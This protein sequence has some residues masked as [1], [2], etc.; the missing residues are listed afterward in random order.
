MPVVPCKYNAEW[1]RVGLISRI[2]APH[3]HPLFRIYC[4]IAL[5]IIITMNHCY[6]S[7]SSYLYTC[8]L[9]IFGIIIIN[10]LNLKRS[11]VLLLLQIFRI[12][13]LH[14]ARLINTLVRYKQNDRIHNIC[15]KKK[16]R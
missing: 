11:L 4:F 14:A 12:T 15:F 8:S 9:S 6:L 10:L 2:T 3:P 7:A 1:C 13:N 16:F 5:F